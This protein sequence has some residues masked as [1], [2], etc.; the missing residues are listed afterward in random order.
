MKVRNEFHAELLK[1]REYEL[2]QAIEERAKNQDWIGYFSISRQ[3][4]EI[5]NSLNDYETQ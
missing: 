1:D 5:R 3:V 2:M 4:R